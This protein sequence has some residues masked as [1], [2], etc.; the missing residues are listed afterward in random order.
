[1]MNKFFLLLWAFFSVNA[2]NYQVLAEKIFRNETGGLNGRVDN[3]ICWRNGEKW[4][5]MGIGH[6]IWYPKDF[7]GPFE[8]QFPEFV[9]FAAKYVRVPKIARGP[10]P[11][12]MTD[13]I[14]GAGKTELSELQKF[15]ENTFTIQAAFI[16]QR[17]KKQVADIKKAAGLRA[18]RR[19]D[20]L[21][22]TERGFFAVL[23]YCNM[24]GTGLSEKERYRE[25]GWGLVQVLQTMKDS[26]SRDYV[27]LFAD[28]AI[29][30][31]E[32]RVC[33]APDDQR[34][35]ERKWLTGW[36]NRINRYRLK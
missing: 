7:R 13:R 12:N 11:W 14:E 15:L 28:A 35:Q 24:K 4:A 32:K 25:E 9:A 20:M 19:L 23:D 18:S 10:C 34:T 6:F 3:L 8:E 27:D 29:D 22:K 33:N 2:F 31:L 36:K 21:L 17:F 16:A 1:M 30:T 26:K 5:S